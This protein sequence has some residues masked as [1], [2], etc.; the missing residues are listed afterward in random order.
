MLCRAAL[1]AVL[2][3]ALA[4]VAAAAPSQRASWAKPQMTKVVEAGLM[5]KSVPAFRGEQALTQGALEQVVAGLNARFAEAAVVPDPA[6]DPWPG[7]TTSTG[8]TSATTTPAPAPAAPWQPYDYKAAEPAKAV[9][10]AELDRVLVKALGLAPAA[11]KV[12]T[13]LVRAGLKPPAHAG[14]ETI[15][16]LIGLRFN[17]PAK[18]DDLELLPDEP[19]TR[20]EAA[21]SVAAALGFGADSQAW[22]TELASSLEL[23][24][25]S[26]WQRKILATAVHYVGYPYV[27]GGTSPATETPAGVTAPGGFDCSGFVWRVYKLTP[28]AGSGPLASILRGRTTYQ[29]SGEVGKAARIYKTQNLKPGDVLFFG[30]GPRSKPGEVD[31]TGIY[32]GGGWMVHSSG[33]GTTIVPFDGWYAR[34]FA[35]ARRPLREAGLDR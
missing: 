2:P 26:G 32:L 18:E 29:M 8:T 13:A 1:V 19:V 9:T 21:Y 16:R 7:D 12:R 23:P 6:P 10:L 27:W 5:A 20:A 17:H 30:R 14:T 24:E 33:N 34:S 25:L 3:L 35:W 22:V 4:G 11:E 31:H 15:A 28:Y